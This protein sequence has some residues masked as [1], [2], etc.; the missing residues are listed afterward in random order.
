[1]NIELVSHPL[2][3]YV[4][5]SVILLRK[6]GVPFEFHHVD[7]KNKPE[8]FLAVSPRGKV[9]VLV[10]QPDVGEAKTAVFESDVINEYLDETNPPRLLPDDP[11]ERA[12]LRG[13]VEVA[14]DVFATMVSVVYGKTEEKW[15]GGLDAAR[16]V[17][18]RVER[19]LRGEFFAG[20]SFGLVDVAF[21]PAFYRFALLTEKTGIAF[22]DGVPEV[23]AWAKRL[24]AHPSVQ[25]SVAPDF[26]E[27]YEVALRENGAWLASRLR[28]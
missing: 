11:L 12:R 21:A 7:L 25:A 5:R 6:K 15:R 26:V 8:W 3:P 4:Q 14:N 19:E 24:V 20:D 22:I 18:A 9:P 13:F 16:R 17:L 23:E 27:R 1:V 2:C 28:D 10:V